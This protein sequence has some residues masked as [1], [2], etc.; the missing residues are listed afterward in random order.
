MNEEE[1]SGV[2]SPDQGIAAPDYT[3]DAGLLSMFGPLKGFTRAVNIVKNAMELT[4]PASKR[5]VDVEVIDDTSN[6]ISNMYKIVKKDL[7]DSDLGKLF[8]IIKR[9]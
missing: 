2:P 5:T 7:L 8:K 4:K 9:G 1:L 3:L 6:A